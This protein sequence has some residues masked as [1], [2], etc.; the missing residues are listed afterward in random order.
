[1][2]DVDKTV[3]VGDGEDNRAAKRVKQGI[4][5][6][7]ITD[8]TECNANLS[9]QRKKRQVRDR[10][11]YLYSITYYKTGSLFYAMNFIFVFNKCIDSFFNDY[12]VLFLSLCVC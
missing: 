6:E 12:C 2:M 9:A 8:L 1:M 11:I 5:D 4:S 10:K 3:P 7:V